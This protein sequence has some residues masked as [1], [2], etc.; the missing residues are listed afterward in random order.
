[1]FGEERNECLE[2]N[3]MNNARSHMD[4]CQNVS[5]QA[6]KTIP[7]GAGYFR[8]TSMFREGHGECLESNQPNNGGSHMDTCQNVSGQLWKVL[9]R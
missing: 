8:L 1:M 4:S 6:W 2:S 5:G 9:P 3:A 7:E